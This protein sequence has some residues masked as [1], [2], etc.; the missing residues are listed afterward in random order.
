MCQYNQKEAVIYTTVQMYRKDRMTYLEHLLKWA[1]QHQVVVGVKLVRGAYLDKETDYAKQKGVASVLCG[2]KAATDANFEAALT[3]ILSHLDYFALF[4]GIHNEENVLQTLQM[5]KKI[6][7][8]MHKRIHF[9]QLLGMCDHLSF[10][11]AH[12]GFQVVKYIPFGPLQDAIPYLIRRLEENTAVMS[13]SKRELELY[14]KEKIR[15]YRE[16]SS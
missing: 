14:R 5:V 12:A 13:Q 6:K 1:Q 7:V 15:R 4:L 9:S 3:F 10:N 16:A 2:S 11:L 8:R